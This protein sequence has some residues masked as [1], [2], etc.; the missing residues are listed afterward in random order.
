MTDPTIADLEQQR[1]RLK[2]DLDAV[3][4]HV[5]AAGHLPAREQQIREAQNKIDELKYRPFAIK[6]AELR[7]KRDTLT[8]ELTGLTHRLAQLR[9]SF[10]NLDAERQLTLARGEDPAAIIERRD[11][12]EA[13]LR[14]CE[15]DIAETTSRLA[16]V[17]AQ[18][19]A[20]TETE[21]EHVVTGRPA[22]GATP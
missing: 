14:A 15:R 7:Q 19:L 16:G 4:G 12:V 9:A 3:K 8:A 1:D 21:A 18:L 6:A 20:L 2:E 10:V 11:E 17:R 22:P 13:E 5:Q